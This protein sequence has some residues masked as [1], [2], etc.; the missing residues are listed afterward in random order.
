MGCQ[1]GPR[2]RYRGWGLYDG[3][4]GSVAKFELTGA[5]SLR[6]PQNGSLLVNATTRKLAR[7]PDVFKAGKGGRRRGAQSAQIGFGGYEGDGRAPCQLAAATRIGTRRSLGRTGLGLIPPMVRVSRAS[8][9]SLQALSPI[10]GA[11]WLRHPGATMRGIAP[12]PMMTRMRARAPD[13]AAQSRAEANV[14]SGIRSRPQVLLRERHGLRRSPASVLQKGGWRRFLTTIQRTP[15]A[16]GWF[17]QEP[18][19]HEDKPGPH[20][21]K[22]GGTMAARKATLIGKQYSATL[23][24]SPETLQALRDKH[25]DIEPDFVRATGYGFDA[26]TESEARYLARFKPADAIRDRI[27]AEGR[28]RGTGSDQADAEGLN[29]PPQGHAKNAGPASIID[30]HAE[31]TRECSCCARGHCGRRGTAGRRQGLGRRAYP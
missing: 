26:L 29:G 14:H 5:Y 10:C 7:S 4:Q 23:A 1:Q 8:P 20:L 31:L 12:Q 22:A 27:L 28:R 9:R 6:G 15:I 3:D 21:F 30:F 25:G 19:R 24:L 13:P 16:Q 2:A 18:D 11:T 17:S